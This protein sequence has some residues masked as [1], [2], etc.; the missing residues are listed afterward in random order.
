MHLVA[1]LGV[2]ISKSIT[3]GLG[4]VASSASHLGD[5]SIGGELCRRPFDGATNPAFCPER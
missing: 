2:G 3:G 1:A 4:S 5:Q